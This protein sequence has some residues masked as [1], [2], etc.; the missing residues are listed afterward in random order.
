MYLYFLQRC[1]PRTCLGVRV[2]MLIVVSPCDVDE[3][4]NFPGPQFCVCKV[5]VIIST[6]ELPHYFII[7]PLYL[8]GHT[9]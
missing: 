3:I 1:V 2:P 4:C 8:G 9:L 5:G 6:L 7:T